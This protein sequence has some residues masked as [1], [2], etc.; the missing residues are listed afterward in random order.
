MY[1]TCTCAKCLP[2][3]TISI[4]PELELL[5]DRDCSE[6]KILFRHRLADASSLPETEVG[7]VIVVH[8]RSVCGDEPLREE[9]VRILIMSPVETQG[10]DVCKDLGAARDQDTIHVGR[11]KLRDRQEKRWF[12]PYPPTFAS[13][14]V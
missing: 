8:K 13:S 12:D 6:K 5:E 2:C 4:V 3:S 1:G 9:Q 10:A 14:N 11:S 7:H